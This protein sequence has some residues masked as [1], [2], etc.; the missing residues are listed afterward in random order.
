MKEGEE[1]RIPLKV[2]HLPPGKPLDTFFTPSP[3]LPPI[4]S[5]P[6]DRNKWT[7]PL[8]IY[9]Q[10]G[11]RETHLPHPFQNVLVP[12]VLLALTRI[13]AAYDPLSHSLALS[14]TLSHSLALSRTKIKNGSRPVPFLRRLRARGEDM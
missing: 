14:R 7:S 3:L 8:R 4:S 13:C 9:R 10:G 5:L 2:G 11:S 1:E 12:V 6:P